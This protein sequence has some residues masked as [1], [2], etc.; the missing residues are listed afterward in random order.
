MDSKPMLFACAEVQELLWQIIHRVAA[1]WA[2]QE[3][4]MQEALLH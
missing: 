2:L 4:L 3:D 1:D